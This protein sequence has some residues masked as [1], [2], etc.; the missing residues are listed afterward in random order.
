MADVRIRPSI[1]IQCGEGK[2]IHVPPTLLEEH[3]GQ[4]FLR[5]RPSSHPIV[6]LVTQST[7]KQNAS[8]TSSSKLQELLK[9][10][11][12]AAATRLSQDNDGTEADE[13]KEDMWKDA[14]PQ[15]ESATESKK[16][17]LEVPSGS[18]VVEISVAGQVV[19]ILCQGTR[20]SKAD[21]LVRLVPEDLS[22]IFAFLK[23]DV[24]E[25]TNAAKRQYS[26]KEKKTL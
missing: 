8:F 25:A 6:A 17:K 9:M 3:Q 7:V 14:A 23:D 21:L 20:P 26:K 4:Q 1:D 10:R 13:S 2:W 5:L 12:E 18:Y 16:R 15:K 19:H 24:S 11:N 22:A